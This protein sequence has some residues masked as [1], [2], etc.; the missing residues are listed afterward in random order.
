MKKCI[1]KN[2]IIIFIC[3]IFSLF[4]LI[5]KN[6]Y[7]KELLVHYIDV[8]QGESILIQNENL[9][10]LID[11]GT[12]D[13]SAKLLNYLKKQ[14]V[15]NLNY[16]FLTHPHDDHI[17][18]ITYILK[19]MKIDKIF[20]PKI[21][22]NTP[23]FKNF[24]KE[25]NSKNIKIDPLI[26]PKTM[27]LNKNIKIEVFSPTKD[28]Y[29]NLNNYSLVFKLNFKN[30]NFLFTGDAEKEI[31]NEL[32]NLDIKSNILKIGHHGSK[33][34]SIEPFLDKVNPDIAIISCGLGND[35]GHPNKTLLNN[36]L[37]R[38]IKLYR[39]DLNGSITLICDKNSI[40]IKKEKS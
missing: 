25:L 38:N 29:D 26:A 4:L 12:E 33:T 39:T 22:A 28:Y 14:N 34:S 30:Y 32:L 8:G 20:S 36:L 13:T 37:D 5:P 17:G 15:H 16:V 7:D 19:N 1:Y 27:K 10:I 35:Y 40:K 2:Y 18:G 6:R 21:T 31:E 23:I 9:N 11:S 24:A 3:I